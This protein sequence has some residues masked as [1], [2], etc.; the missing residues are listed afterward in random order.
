MKAFINNREWQC[1]PSV[2]L[3]EGMGVNIRMV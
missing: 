2:P 3:C 1:A